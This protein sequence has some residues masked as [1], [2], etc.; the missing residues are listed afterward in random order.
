MRLA[1]L[2]LFLLVAASR[3]TASTGQGSCTGG[4]SDDPRTCVGSEQI[5][6]DAGAPVLSP[7]P[8]PAPPPNPA[9]VPI[10][11][12]AAEEV[13]AGLAEAAGSEQAGAKADA[14]A[15]TAQLAQAHAGLQ[16][17]RTQLGAAVQQVESLGAQL[18]QQEAELRQLEARHAQLSGAPVPPPNPPMWSSSN[19]PAA[20]S[21]AGQHSGRML[22]R[23]G[24]RSWLDHFLLLAAVQVGC[25]HRQDGRACACPGREAQHIDLTRLLRLR[26]QYRTVH[27]P[28]PLLC[29]CVHPGGRRTRHP[30]SIRRQ[31]CPSSSARSRQRDLR[32]PGLLGDRSFSS[33]EAA[34]LCH[35][36]RCGGQGDC[37]QR[38]G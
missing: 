14:D 38:E 8:A 9:E 21:G 33:R 3:S 35:C 18:R 37:V 11:P 2:L 25:G 36:G 20:S 31:P 12:P 6:I 29:L 26:R 23:G 28:F 24:R 19:A 5:P 27:A 7:P 30:S 22:L 13:Q 32:A 15:L 17:L 34:P 1:Q 16:A 10:S 4:V